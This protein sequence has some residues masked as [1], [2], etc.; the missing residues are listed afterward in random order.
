MHRSECRLWGD[1]TTF[2]TWR[3]LSLRR[4]VEQHIRPRQTSART[5]ATGV[6]PTQSA[7]ASSWTAG[8]DRGARGTKPSVAARVAS[9]GA[10]RRGAP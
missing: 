10:R 6:R 5:K 8:L 4:A 9:N 3:F 2:E 1:Q 7:L